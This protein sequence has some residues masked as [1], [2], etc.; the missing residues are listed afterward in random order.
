MAG[1][2]DG[3]N[4]KSPAKTF[5]IGFDFFIKRTNN[6]ILEN[7]NLGTKTGA[8]KSPEQNANQTSSFI[9]KVSFKLYKII[10]CVRSSIFSFWDC[11]TFAYLVVVDVAGCFLQYSAFLLNLRSTRLQQHTDCLFKQIWDRQSNRLQQSTDCLFERT[12][13]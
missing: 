10:L 6:V 9:E 11:N 1:N 13:D 2:G 5:T 4:Q 12:W 7:L 3:K 8:T